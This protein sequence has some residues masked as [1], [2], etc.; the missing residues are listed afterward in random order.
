MTQGP[1]A[2]A[3]GTDCTDGRAGNLPETIRV[4]EAAPA[5][6]VLLGS[7]EV[8]A[9]EAHVHSEHEQAKPKL[10]GL[11]SRWAR[12]SIRSASRPAVE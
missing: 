3:C 6:E 11:P 10:A 7:D 2:K 4:K 1:R 9:K 5:R 8:A 12:S